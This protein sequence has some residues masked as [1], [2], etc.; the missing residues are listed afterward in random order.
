LPFPSAGT[1]SSRGGEG[2]SEMN[3]TMSSIVH[4]M[5]E[6]DYIRQSVLGGLSHSYY[7]AWWT[8]YGVL[9][10]RTRRIWRHVFKDLA[11]PLDN[12]ITVDLL[13]GHPRRFSVTRVRV[14]EGVAPSAAAPSSS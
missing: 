12:I 9:G 8:R 10:D 2:G 11:Q 13:N 4:N 7:L 6:Y 14:P 1:S 3:F 5:C